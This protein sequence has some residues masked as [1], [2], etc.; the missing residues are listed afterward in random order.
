MDGTRR[1]FI[2][3]LGG[4]AI[5]SP[6]PSFGQLV[7]A[8]RKVAV[9][10]G[11]ANDAESHV[12]IGAFEQGLRKEGWIPGQN[13][14]LIYRFAAGDAERMSTLAKE[15][16]D[17]GP[18]VVVAHST[19]VVREVLQATKSIPVVFVVV[20]DPVG[21]GFTASIPHPGGNATG[22]TNLD[23]T[24]TG[25]LLTILKQ[26]RPKLARVALMYNPDTVANGGLFYL[27]PFERAAPL[28]RV[29]A[30]AA[31]VRSPDEIEKIVSNLDHDAETGLIVMPDNF[32]TV[33]R[34]LI[35]SLAAKWRIPTIYPYRYFAEAGGLMSYG[36]DVT[37]LF[38][39]ASDYVSRILK[40]AEPSGLPVQAPTKFELVINLKTAKALDLSVPRSLLA[41]AD[42]LID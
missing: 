27:R 15:L 36:V 17:L 24:I 7:A 30:I 42:Y 32:T 29:E 31:Q 23:S 35:I 25:K 28:F 5:V 37:D 16:V 2:A 3:L 1:R 13:V 12:R 10:M 6:L 21:S 22:F 41:G 11:L 14:E 19:P 40:G 18:D 38:S 8:P 39:R 33:H 20:A 26:I 34:Q 9:L 4:T